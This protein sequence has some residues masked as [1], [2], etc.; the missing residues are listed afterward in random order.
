MGWPGRAS[1]AGVFNKSSLKPKLDTLMD[2]PNRDLP[3]TFHIVGDS[4]FPIQKSLM[5]PYKSVFG[6]ALDRVRSFYNK[7]LSSKRQVINILII[8]INTLTT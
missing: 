5:T 6:E 1:D 7:C 3:N 2:M 4:A 8:D